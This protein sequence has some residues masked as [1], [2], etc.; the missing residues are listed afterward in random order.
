MPI[1]LKGRSLLTLKD[2][3]KEEIEYLLNLSFDLKSKKRSGIKGNLLSGKNIALL[4]EK[5]S[6]RTRCA[7]EV[8]ALDE[9][10]HITFLGK[11]DTHM[12]G[13]ESI[14]DTA[15]VLGRFYD[16]IE[17]R[18]FR[19]ET[20]EILAKYSGVPVWNGLTDDYHPTQVL[21]DILTIKEHVSKPLNQVKLVYLGDA[22]SNMGNSLMIISAKLGLNF[23]SIS[24]KEL[25][26]KKEL[27]DSIKESTLM[28]GANITI[29][30]DIRNLKNADCIYTDIWVSMGEENLVQDRVRLLSK[31][32]VTEEFMQKT[33]NND[34]IF[35]HCL[36]SFHDF[37]TEFADKMKKEKNLDI[38]EVTDEVFKSKNSKVFDQAENRMH[39]IKAVITATI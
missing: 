29:T 12:G 2:Y 25:H 14:K 38:R 3:T 8:A 17:F 31:F 6:T 19:Q 35:M 20:V 1:N 30:D 13:K 39:T 9:G 34:C 32:K 21:A 26:P 33:E 4:F 7:F 28:S 11:N 16:G 18:G 22:R 10:A 5:N 15:L 24:P 37:E 23:Y 36:P 27:V